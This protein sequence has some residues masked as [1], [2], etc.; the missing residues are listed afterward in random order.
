M[1]KWKIKKYVAK[2]KNGKEI[3]SYTIQNAVSGFYLRPYFVPDKHEAIVSEK[4]GNSS[5]SIVPDEENY[6]LK[7]NK[8]GGDGLYSKGVSAGD[9]EPW[10]GTDENEDEYRWQ[11][12]LVE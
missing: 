5:F 3:V 10:F 8:M 6:L 2:G 11:L 4:D 12:M 1:Q 9:D 7:S